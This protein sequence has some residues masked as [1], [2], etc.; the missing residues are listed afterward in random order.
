M[1]KYDAAADCAREESSDCELFDGVVS[2]ARFGAALK[3]TEAATSSWK[4]RAAENEVA[5]PAFAPV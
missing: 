1:T 2:L 5:G 3:L 4:L